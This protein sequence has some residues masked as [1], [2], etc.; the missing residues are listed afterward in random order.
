MTQRYR[1]APY[2]QLLERDIQQAMEEDAVERERLVVLD[3]ID[4][5]D[6]QVKP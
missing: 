4:V 2:V 6:L 3:E 5:T 1:A